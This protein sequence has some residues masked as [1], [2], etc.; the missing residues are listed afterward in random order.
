[1]KDSYYHNYAYP[2]GYSLPVNFRRYY[3]EDL[4]DFF[5]KMNTQLECYRAM[6]AYDGDNWV[7]PHVCGKRT[8]YLSML[9]AGKMDMTWEEVCKL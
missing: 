1:M 7:I 3:F 8:A 9:E 5:G 4:R 2:Q 6:L